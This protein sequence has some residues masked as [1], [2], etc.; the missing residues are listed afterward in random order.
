MKNF[1]FFKDENGNSVFELPRQQRDIIGNGSNMIFPTA[2]ELNEAID[3]KRME[4]SIQDAFDAYDTLRYIGVGEK[5]VLFYKIVSNYKY[6]LELYEVSGNSDEEKYNN[7]LEEIGKLCRK[8][9]D[10]FHELSVRIGL[11][12]VTDQQYIFYLIGHPWIADGTACALIT[13]RI[14]RRYAGEAI[15]KHVALQNHEFME[16]YL[17]F[18]KTEKGIAEL[19]YWEKEL[20]GYKMFDI[21]PLAVGEKAY[22]KD[23]VVPISK[24]IM[25]TVAKN[26]KTS[27]YNVFLFAF[28]VAV[29]HFLGVKDTMISIPDSCRIKKVHFYIVGNLVRNVPHRLILSEE[30]TLAEAFRN[31]IAKSSKDIKNHHVATFDR[32]LQFCTSYN[33]YRKPAGFTVKNISSKVGNDQRE[34]NFFGIVLL[35]MP[36][37]LQLF[38]V[39]DYHVSKETL[40][41]F[42]ESMTKTAELLLE[43][44]DIK[45]GDTK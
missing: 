45:V 41:A 21:S 14:M 13:D 2:I 26:F 10:M 22:M 42:K 40:T 4:A 6:E 30:E 39:C 43:N 44:P 24:D 12:K 23:Y 33:N 7:A 5:E 37:A 20:S 32:R 8:P 38:F 11:V 34:T 19:E 3:L 36:E 29:Y 9:I 25:E 15:E 18:E 16:Q 28:H 31:S 1:E 35:E 17:Q 27:V